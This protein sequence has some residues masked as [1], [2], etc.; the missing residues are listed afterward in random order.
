MIKLWKFFPVLIILAVC[1]GLL[2]VPA[3]MGVSAA[4]PASGKVCFRMPAEVKVAQG[5]TFEVNVTLYNPHGANMS[6]ATAAV[7]SDVASLLT[8]NSL[9]AGDWPQALGSWIGV[10]EFTYD[11]GG[12]TGTPYLNTTPVLHCTVNFTANATVGG[13]T[14]VRFVT[15]GGEWSD[16]SCAV[17]DNSAIPLDILDWAC[18]QNMTVTIG[19]VF[20]LTVTSSGCCPIN[21]SGGRGTVGPGNSTLFTVSCSENVTLTAVDSDVCC[22]FDNWTVDTGAPTF[23]KSVIISG[24]AANSTHNATASCSVPQYNLTMA[25]NG[26]GITSPVGT[27]SRSCGAVVPINATADPGWRFDN[28]TTTGDISEISDPGGETTTVTVDQDKTVTANFIEQFNLT[29]NV[30]GNGT[31][32]P[33]I[34]NHTYD[35]GTVV[36]ITAAPE[37]CWDFINWTGDVANPDSASTTVTMDANKTVIANFAQASYTL[38]VTVNGN[39]TVTINGTTPASYPN[40]TSWDNCTVVNLNATPDD[41]WAFL[42]WSG[43]VSDVNSSVTNITMYDNYS[44]TAY[45]GSHDFEVRPL[46]LTFTTVEGVNP[47]SKTLE[48]CNSPN[49]TLNWSLSDGGTGWLRENPEGSSLNETD[50]ENITVSVNVAGMAAGDYDATIT[51]TGS[52]PT[53]GVPVSLHIAA[54]E[55]EELPGITVLPAGLSASG[56][57]ISPQQVQPGQDVTISINVAN[58]G[59]KTGSYNA[60]LYINSVVEDSQT[61]SVAAGASKNV[62]FTVSKTATGVYDVSLAGQSGQFEVVGSGGWFGG[63]GLGT[64]GIIAIVVVVIILIVAV[65]FILRGTARPE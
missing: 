39:G 3:A 58:T 37:A 19:D 7:R 23:N 11:G 60:V 9:T 24:M 29:M 28:W 33:S 46:F 17:K 6:V 50:C 51:F 44:I 49:G 4:E 54:V 61:V 31:T 45:F 8:V 38:N 40:I 32:S 43:N 35:N 16:T 30:T 53:Q 27:T 12:S 18:V 21:V 57:S 48:I 59:G 22:V 34:G 20:N 13:V 55:G 5:E 10:G 1:L 2:L 36:N 47:P 56:L 14:T 52:A 63:G 15:D 64:G 26:G 41:D 65:V 62:I 42:G 25:V